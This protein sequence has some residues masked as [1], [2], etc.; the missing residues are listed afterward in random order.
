MTLQ[1]ATYLI[2][3]W[4]FSLPSFAGAW[5]EGSFENDT[6]NDWSYELEIMQDT[7]FL[8]ATLSN[9]PDN[10]YLDSDLCFMAIAA[11]ETIAAIKDRKTDDLPENI[12]QWIQL[13][14][15]VY[16][17]SWKPFAIRAITLCKDSSRSELS[18]LWD[19]GSSKAWIRNLMLIERRLSTPR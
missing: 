3:L 13:N 6:A 9:I 12:K 2:L 5:G 1:N 8:L 7:Q 14:K 15:I 11:A 17:P 4:L 18:Q 16:K 10:E 19:E